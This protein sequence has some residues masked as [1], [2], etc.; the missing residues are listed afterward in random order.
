[1][2]AKYVA[3]N[4]SIPYPPEKRARLD[5]TP[6]EKYTVGSESL[7]PREW[8]TE[9]SNNKESTPKAST[10]SKSKGFKVF[11]W[12]ILADSK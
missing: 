12:N 9:D 4:D 10:T 5:E 11:Q 8:L 2:A 7:I 3:S 6:A 1:M